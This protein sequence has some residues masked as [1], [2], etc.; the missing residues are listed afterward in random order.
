MDEYYGMEEEGW[1]KSLEIIIPVILLI[2]VLLLAASYMG[3]LTG[4]PFIGSLFKEGNINALVIG[5][6]GTVNEIIEKQL[7]PEVPINLETMTPEQLAE[8]RE[9]SF[10]EKYNLLILTEGSEGQGLKI[11]YSGLQHIKYYQSKGKPVI[12]IGRAGYLTE[13]TQERGWNILGFVPVDCVSDTLTDCADQT[14]TLQGGWARISA[15]GETV[16]HKLDPGISGLTTGFKDN[17]NFSETTTSNVHYVKITPEGGASTV[18]SLETATEEVPGVVYSHNLAGGD[19]V[20]FAFHPKDQ[21]P[22]FRAA[23]KMLTGA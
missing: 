3:W 15:P 10:I 9:S 4:V 14:G 13:N 17:L 1:K 11:P 5:D 7:A 6:D 20:Y 16:L 19:I 18:W 8:H 23:I 12:I 21:V 2:V 22:L